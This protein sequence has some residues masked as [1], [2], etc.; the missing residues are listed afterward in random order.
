MSLGISATGWLAIAGIASAGLSYQQGQQQQASAKKSYKQQQAA[1]QAQLTQADQQFNAQNMK[2]P[3]TNALLSS[4]MLSSRG[5]VSGTMLTG[6][7]GITKDK[8]SLQSKTL[9]GA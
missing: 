9:L 7:T 2:S 4:A 8:L 6:T 3:D 5:G 1:A